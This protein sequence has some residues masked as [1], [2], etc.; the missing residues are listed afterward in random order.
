MKEGWFDRIIDEGFPDR[1]MRSDVIVMLQIMS[2]KQRI[3]L[4]FLDMDDIFLCILFLLYSIGHY[5]IPRL[6]LQFPVYYLLE[7]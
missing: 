1:D 4:I 3:K 7:V 2:D 5:N 6:S